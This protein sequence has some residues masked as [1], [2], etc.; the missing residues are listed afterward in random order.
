[1]RTLDKT[2]VT[3]CL[4]RH[5]LVK[6]NAD[7]FMMTRS[8]AEN[9]PYTDLYKAQLKGARNEWLQLVD[10]IENNLTNPLESLKLFI[11]LLINKAEDFEKLS[12]GVIQLFEANNYYFSSRSICKN[13]IIKHI[14]S[15]DYAARLF[16][17]AIHSLAQAFLEKT[18]NLNLE[19]KAL[20]QMRSANKKHG[21]VGDVEILENGNIIESFDAKYGKVYLREE[22][23]EAS[24]KVATHNFIQIVY[25]VTDNPVQQSKEIRTRLKDL[26]DLHNIDFNIISF[27]EYIDIIFARAISAGTAT[28]EELSHLWVSTY[29]RSLTQQ[30]RE[31]A[32]IDEPC[33][34]WVE[35]FNLILKSM[36]V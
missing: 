12:R 9:Y 18:P 19:L 22:I 7:G 1:M 33:H 25:F 6:L 26:S 4:R 23:E 21:N 11:S 8:L 28:E 20:S 24:E 34:Q 14:E 3:P 13:I 5:N 31:L 15:T 27:N 29:I 30:N 10:Q 2:Y 35:S 32:P 17:V 36:F 16:E